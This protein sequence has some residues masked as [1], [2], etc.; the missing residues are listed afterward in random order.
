MSPIG[1]KAVLLCICLFTQ[2]G[3]AKA[4]GLTEYGQQYC[5]DAGIPPEE[6]TLLPPGRGATGQSTSS[7]TEQRLSATDPMSGSKKETLVE[8]GRRLCAK[9]GV[10]L[11]DCKALPKKFRDVSDA[12]AGQEHRTFEGVHPVASPELT[13]QRPVRQARRRAY[14]NEQPIA[15][16][17]RTVRYAPLSDHVSSPPLAA[18]QPA[19]R[20]A[21][22]R[23][24]SYA[25]PPAA[26]Y[27]AARH[28][29]PQ[30][31]IYAPAIAVDRRPVRRDHLRGGYLY[32]PPIAAD[33]KR[34]HRDH[35][36]GGYLYAPPAVADRKPAR[37]EHLRGGYLYA[38]P[39]A[40]NQRR[41]HRR[42]ERA[43]RR[44]YGEAPYGKRCLRSVRYSRP[45][46]Y[47]Y[48]ACD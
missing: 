29:Y 11:E 30:D 24:Y 18:D 12:T 37:R 42:A 34:V 44:V 20:Y 1:K 39:I 14:F 7:S 46:S 15:S 5:A 26:D 27:Q 21:T 6:C 47:R 33:R 16:D 45:P 38:P 8:H 10:P 28:A 35:R 2:L 3:L 43:E 13:N 22:P 4:E 25:S 19:V 9:E 23:S 48:V 17:R 40:A 31:Y 41:D 32:A 36:Q